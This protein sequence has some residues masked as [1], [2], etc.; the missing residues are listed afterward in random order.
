MSAGNFRPKT[1]LPSDRRNQDKAAAILGRV[2]QCDVTNLSP[3][4]YRADWAFSRKKV[5]TAFG[6]YKRRD[7]TFGKYPSI[8]ISAAKYWHLLDLTIKSGLP[9]YL[10]VGCDNGIY[11]HEV[12]GFT[13]RELHIGGNERRAA[14]D[15][16]PVIYIPNAEFKL[17][18]EV[19]LT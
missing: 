19:D 18:A 8:L 11:Y 10:V 15:I 7:F 16:S 3:E 13:H 12:E 1:E 5:I 9:S 14:Y 2:W 4:L 6:E 17:A